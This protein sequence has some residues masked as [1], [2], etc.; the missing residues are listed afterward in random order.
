MHKI[1]YRLLLLTAF[2]LL[3]AFVVISRPNN[4][5]VSVP[6]TDQEP[7]L[8]G[9]ASY[10][11]TSRDEILVDS[12]APNAQITSP[13]TITGSARGTWYFEAT[14]PVVLVD[15]DGL[16]IAEGYITAQDDWMTENFVPFTGT[17]TFTRPAYGDR[18]ALILRASNPSGL[19]ENE[20]AVEI[21]ITF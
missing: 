18:G 4:D 5:S 12:P 1:F 9:E 11:N 16:I 13:I 14:A 6:T 2:I 19:S 7:L 21:P 15:W 3:L 17:L 20:R 8:V 10:T